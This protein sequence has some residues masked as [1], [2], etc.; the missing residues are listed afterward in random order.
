MHPT[1]S[2]CVFV[3]AWALSGPMNVWK[4][5]TWVEASECLYVCGLVSSG[6]VP[7]SSTAGP[8]VS[9]PGQAA[10]TPSRA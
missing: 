4:P 7:R 5:G 9:T 1:R 8:F 6:R 3:E 10:L 2:I